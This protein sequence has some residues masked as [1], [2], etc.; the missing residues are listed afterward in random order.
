MRP[1]PAVRDEQLNTPEAIGPMGRERQ[2]KADL[3]RITPEVEG[4]LPPEAIRKVIDE[5]KA[6]IRYCYE[7]ALQ[8]N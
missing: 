1:A 6:Q 5:H 7:I 4:A 8:K 2:E 3:A